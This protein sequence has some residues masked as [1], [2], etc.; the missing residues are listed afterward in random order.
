[1]S[2]VRVLPAAPEIVRHRSKAMKLVKR[3]R[4]PTTGV[5]LFWSAATA[6]P[7]LW[8]FMSAFKSQA[9]ILINRWG[10]PKVWTLDNFT[11][12]WTGHLKDA[13]YTA[14][15]PL[16][17]YFLN[18]VIVVTF[19]LGLTLLVCVPAAYTLGRVKFRGRQ[20]MMVVILLMIAI[21]VQALII[22]IWKV[23]NG[24]GITDTYPGLILPYVGTAI[25]Y[26]ILLLAAYFRSF[27]SELEDSGKIDGLSMLGVLRRV[28][29]PMSKG[30]I[31]AIT[32]LLAYGFWNDFLF[33]LVLM[34]SGS[35]ETLPVGVVQFTQNTYGAPLNLIMAALTIVTVPI[36]ILY[37]LVQKQL[38]SVQ[39]QLFK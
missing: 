33:A 35:M 9:D 37:I 20:V 5:A 6:L 15:V 32:V 14:S 26:A 4:I 2:D 8:M 34:P 28:V 39:F 3:L 19:A 10:L 38:T 25:P 12:V 31:S 22:P 36:L 1:M 24:L 23:E 13:S 16:S 11:S 30:P 18:S 17:R 21:P 27:P 29:V 7:I